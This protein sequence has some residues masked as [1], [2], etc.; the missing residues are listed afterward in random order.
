VEW[1]IT[2]LTILLALCFC[3][4][5]TQTQEPITVNVTEVPTLE[6]PTTIATPTATP[7]PIRAITPNPTPTP[8]ETIDEPVPDWTQPPVIYPPA[9]PDTTKINF[10]KYV[11]DTFMAEF[12]DSWT[13]QNETFTL[14]DTTI[15]GRDIFKSEGKKVSFI[16]E[17][18]KTRMVV[19]VSDILVPNWYNYIPTIDNAKRSVVSLYPEVNGETAVQNY[20]NAYNNQKVMVSS[21]DVVLPNSMYTEKFFMTYNHGWRIQFIVSNQTLDKYRELEYRMTQSVMTEGMQRGKWW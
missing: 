9:E 12:P 4:G 17:D 1:K 19:L 20:K 7:M 2:I 14:K 16:S 21:Y 15:N 10:T 11:G 8:I 5:C 3:M 18:S 13:V 6:I